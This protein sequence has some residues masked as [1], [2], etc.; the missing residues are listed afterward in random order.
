MKQK[1][2]F[3]STGVYFQC[4]AMARNGSGIDGKD[5][6]L[7]QVWRIL[8]WRITNQDG[9]I[10]I[11]QRNL[12]QSFSILTS[13]QSCSK[14]PELGSGCSL[15]LQKLGLPPQFLFF[16]FLM[17]FE[18]IEAH[19]DTNEV[20]TSDSTMIYVQLQ[21]I[22]HMKITKVRQH[23]PICTTTWHSRSLS[24]SHLCMHVYM[25]THTH[26]NTHMHMYPLIES[27]TI[28]THCLRLPSTPYPSWITSENSSG[29]WFYE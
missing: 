5:P 3:S 16:L 6:S 20:E 12:P 23:N 27:Y 17:H 14:H 7:Q 25:H 18:C 2:A 15:N 1:S 10:L 24:H 9:R 26:T 28:S 19:F 13:G 11:L 21:W 22:Q 29:L 8:C 4:R